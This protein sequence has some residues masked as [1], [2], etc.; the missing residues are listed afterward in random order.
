MIWQAVRQ[1]QPA[2]EEAIQRFGADRVGF[3]LGTSTGGI[4]STEEAL[5][6]R[7]DT[8]RLPEHY[9]CRN[10]H[11]MDSA[12]RHVAGF[13]GISGPVYAVSAACSSGAKALASARRLIEANICD[14]VLAGGVDSIC[15]M[16]VHGFHSL[17]VLSAEKCRPFDDSERGMNVAEG[18]TLLLLERSLHSPA[19]SDVVF[20]GV[21]ES[22]DA[23]HLSAPDPTGESQARA[24]QECLKDAGFGAADL[25]YINAHGT[26]TEAN[27]HAELLAL[28]RVAPE[29]PASSTKGVL[30]HQLG[31]AGATEA[32]VAIEVLRGASVSAN[33]AVRPRDFPLNLSKPRAVMSN[34]FAFGGANV[35]LLFCRGIPPGRRLSTRPPALRFSI[36]AFAEQVAVAEGDKT[37]GGELL[38]GRARARASQLSRL[39]A[40]LAA[41][42]GLSKAELS[43]IPIV[44]GSALGQVQVTRRLIELFFDGDSSPLAFQTSVH[45]AVAGLL[46]LALGNKLPSSSVA[47][48][49]D[50]SFAA[51][52][53]GALYLWTHPEHLRVLVLCADETPPEDLGLP[54]FETAGTAFLLANDAPSALARVEL[55]PRGDVAP[56]ELLLRNPQASNQ[57]SPQGFA[58]SHFLANLDQAE[59]E[60]RYIPSVHSAWAFRIASRSEPWK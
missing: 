27:D 51:L 31:A 15:R 40:H 7:R 14:V 19:D 60:A 5:L 22:S 17:G 4:L 10:G 37:F 34:S 26:G 13:F 53:E 18:A 11:T 9:S 49:D 2:L 38:I 44:V 6:E 33:G 41:R 52:L 8:G 54:R 29:I 28:E 43:Q 47:G 25:D 57:I 21:G 58:L 23:Y 12:A 16:T 48:G 46:S 55:V 59:K 56:G 20:A 42:V 1:M 36:Q 24:M 30:G 39:G 45:N 3:V 32:L 35:S 50:S